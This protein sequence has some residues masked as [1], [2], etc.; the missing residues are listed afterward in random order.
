M[1]RRAVSYL[2]LAWRS[3]GRAPLRTG[4]TVSGIA[5]SVAV[6]M[7]VSGFYRGYSTS[8]ERTVEKMG[9]EVLV[10]AKGCPYEAATLVMKGGNIPMYVDEQIFELIRRDPDVGD[11]SRM[12]MQGT[13]AVTGSR[14]QVFLGV[15]DAYLRL[16]PWMTLQR[17]RWFGGEEAA[18]AVLGYNVA[19]FLRA[20]LG[21]ELPAGPAGQTARVVGVLDRSGTQD[22]GLIF[23]PLTYAQKAFDRQGKLTGIAVK[24][25]RIE[26][27]D[28]FLDRT[29]E[30]PSVQVITLAQVRGT[31]LDLV[32]TA[33]IFIMAAALV[34]I[35][36]A[37]FGV[38]NTTLMSVHER[39]FEIGVM[40]VLGASPANV[41]ALVWIESTILCLAGG[42]AGEGA[43]LGL[44]LWTEEAVRALIPYAPPGRL[45]ALGPGIL[46]AGLGGTVLIGLAAGF[47]PAWKA[48]VMRPIR[49]IRGT[50]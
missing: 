9:Y 5:T 10:T 28:A 23:L 14:F 33:R 44:G 4:L 6:F 43:T 29:F 13:P 22:D 40:K 46:A 25:A 2:L 15:D 27:M 32:G 49:T 35:L 34:A 26:R 39:S 16:K 50:A 12:F 8:L 21:S 36:V 37:S 42:I 48:A 3:L 20:D 1:I 30:I 19:E 45:V 17:G 47:Y 24:L 7:T 38:F 31:I 41:F 11:L 18:E